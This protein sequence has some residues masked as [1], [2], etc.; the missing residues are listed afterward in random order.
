MLHRSY[1]V[2]ISIIATLVSLIEVILP[3]LGLIQP[4]METTTY[5]YTMFGLTIA[6]AIGRYIKQDLEDGKFDGV[7]NEPVKEIIVDEKNTDRD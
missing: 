2:I 6:I 5:G 3:H 4:I 7:I 1:T